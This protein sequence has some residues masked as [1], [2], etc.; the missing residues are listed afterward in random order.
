MG[1]FSKPC[2]SKGQRVFDSPNIH[3][4]FYLKT[5]LLFQVMSSN[6]VD[7]RIYSEMRLAV[8]VGGGGREQIFK[9]VW[10]YN[11]IY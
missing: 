4:I 1:F 9:N 6:V 10:I 7:S 5:S 8:G 11:E 3:D 2:I